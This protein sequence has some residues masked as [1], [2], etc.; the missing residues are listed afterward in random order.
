MCAGTGPTLQSVVCSLP[1]LPCAPSHHFHSCLAVFDSC[2]C[3]LS[4]RLPQ[5]CELCYAQ[6]A[7]LSHLNANI[8]GRA[9]PCQPDWVGV[10]EGEPR[11]GAMGGRKPARRT[12]M[13]GFWE[14][15]TFGR[16]D[17]RQHCTVRLLAFALARLGCSLTLQ[18]G[19]PHYGQNYQN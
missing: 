9:L 6:G 4:C 16:R 13:C 3:V 19:D 8:N 11:A 2:L 7:V 12:I 17:S 5:Q 1:V 15:W 10:G 18:R 14:F